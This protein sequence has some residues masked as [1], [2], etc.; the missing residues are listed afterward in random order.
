MRQ[1]MPWAK[2]GVA[3]A[4]ALALAGCATFSQD[5]GFSKVEELTRERVGQAPKWSR[6]GGGEARAR[7]DELLAS[8]MTAETAVELSL[9]NNPALQASYYELG[10]AE[11]DLVRAGRLRNPS[12]SFLNVRNAESYKI[13]RS[14]LFDVIGLLTMPLAREVE[15]RRFESIQIEVAAQAVATATESRR[16]YYGAVA[17]AQLVRYFEQVKETAEISTE[18]AKRMAQAGSGSKLALMREQAFYAESVARLARARQ[19]AIAE[20]ERLVRALGFWGSDIEFKL[21]ERLPNVPAAPYEPQDAE[22]TAIN[23]RLDVL[24]AKRSTEAV[25]R[26][27]GLAK[28]TRVVNVLEAGYANLSEGGDPRKNGYE[29]TLELPIFDWG[30][31]RVARA[32]SVYLQSVAR[33]ADVAIRARSQVREAYSAYRTAFDLARHYRDEVVPLRKRISDES[34]LRYNG[35]LIGP[36]ELLADAREQIIAVTAAIEAQRDFWLADSS[37]RTALTAGAPAEQSISRSRTSAAAPS[38][39]H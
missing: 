18:L 16:A 11:A 26:A 8:A 37:L 38:A 23:A 33:T 34:V 29:I 36:F 4:V 10:V 3:L 2:R 1:A 9:L 7:T 5:G 19:E 27:L 6:N 14:V 12:L 35:M 13:E 31:T 21:P 25:A 15:S 28:A 20:R 17:A 32:Q 39:G 24:A 22:Q 30:S